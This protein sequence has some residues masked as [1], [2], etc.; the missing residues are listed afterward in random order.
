MKKNIL[1]VFAIATFGF[2]LSSCGE[3]LLENDYYQGIDAEGGLS[4]VNNISTALNGAYYNLFYYPF[5]GNYAINIGD[6]PT[7]ISYWNSK[8]N[9]FNNIYS[10]TVVDPDTY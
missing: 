9:H 8:T 10:Y 1:K 2:R 3:S 6:I 5:A 7:D 4:S